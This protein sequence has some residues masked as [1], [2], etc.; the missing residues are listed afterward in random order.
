MYAVSSI[1]S[2][3]ASKNTERKEEMRAFK[4]LSPPAFSYPSMPEWSASLLLRKASFRKER[5]CVFYC[6]LFRFIVP[7]FTVFFSFCFGGLEE[8]EFSFFSHFRIYDKQK[9]KQTR[10]LKVSFRKKKK[11][12]PDMSSAWWIIQLYT[13]FF[14]SS[15]WKCIFCLFFYGM[16]M[17]SAYMC[18]VYLIPRN[19]KAS[20]YAACTLQ[21]KPLQ[22]REKAV[23]SILCFNNFCTILLGE[24]V[25]PV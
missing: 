2:A 24:I 6:T 13:C 23:L 12:R 20:F 9:N 8:K 3:F 16:V 5:R 14:F 15:S 10:K 21:K 19:S 7:S 4:T 22:S 1:L 11:K 25:N 17:S 18:I